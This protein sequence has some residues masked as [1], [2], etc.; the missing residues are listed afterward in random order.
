MLV[1]LWVIVSLLFVF[2]QSVFA[3][4]SADLWPFWDSSDDTNQTTVDHKAWDEFLS[5]YVKQDESGI[6]KVAY[7]SVSSGDKKALKDYIASL[8]RLDPRDL[9]R[10]EQFAYWINL[11]NALT[12]DVVLAYP[13]KKSI[14]K[15]GE[16][17]FSIG[18]WDDE[19][20]EIAGQPVTLN[21]IEH[22]VLRPIFK[23]HRIHYAVNC[24]SIGCPNLATV[25]YTQSNLEELLAKGE[26][27]YLN[28]PRGVTFDNKGRL[29][30]SKIF[31]WYGDDFASN[32][33]DFVAYLSRH[34]GTLSD[35]LKDY[36]GKIRYDYDWNLN[37]ANAQ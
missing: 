3:A 32:K 13:N 7:G 33:K 35:K 22:R 29:Q 15:M 30:V 23:D 9:S 12:V 17:F 10:T 34:H 19:L 37:T 24:A 21:D 20:V 26:Q 27:D 8:T 18:P 31:D 16:G 2:N 5:A 4:P 25:A 1:R 36:D 11:Y 6:N 28:H 14:L